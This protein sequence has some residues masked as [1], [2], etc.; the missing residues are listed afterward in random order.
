MCYGWRSID[1]VIYL[2]ISSTPALRNTASIRWNNSAR[3]CSA[4]AAVSAAAGCADGTRGSIASRAVDAART[5]FVNDH[6][7]PPANHQQVLDIVA[8]HHDK[9]PAFI[10]AGVIDNR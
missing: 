10:D 1:R 9:L 5:M 3:F 7:G 6:V 2:S 8:P 4:A